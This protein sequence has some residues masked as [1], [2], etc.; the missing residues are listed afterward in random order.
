MSQQDELLRAARDY[1][2]RLGWPVFVLSS[3]KVPVPNCERCR[4]EHTTPQQMRDCGCLTCHGFYAAT[5]DMARVEKMVRLHPRGLLAIRTGAVSGTVVIDVDAH[6][7]PAMRQMIADGLLPRTLAQRTGSGYHLLYAH[8]GVRISSGPGKGGLGIDIKSDD[9]YIV[10]APSVHPRTGRP[11]R[12]LGPLTWELARLP[13]YW[14][15]RLREPDRPALPARVPVEA[16]RGTRYAQGAVR[17][18]LADLLGT[19]EGERNHILNKSAFI[20]G[21]LVGAGMLDGEDAT[22]VLEDAGQRIGL[23]PGEVRRSVAS[24]LRAGARCPRGG[25]R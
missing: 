1:I 5:L 9:A 25:R 21:Q 24:G 16:V 8:P 15:K 22:A 11:Y 4:Q 23:S 10:A 13:R 12:W 20:I 14:V 18:E 3:S 2:I 17:R 19:E 6:G 7:L